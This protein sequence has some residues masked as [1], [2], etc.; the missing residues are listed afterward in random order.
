MVSGVVV[1]LHAEASDLDAFESVDGAEEEV[2]DDEAD[3]DEVEGE[4]AVKDYEQLVDRVVDARFLENES[5]LR[6][7]IVAQDLLNRTEDDANREEEGD[8]AKK[9]AKH[10]RERTHATA[11]LGTATARDVFQTLR[12]HLQHIEVATRSGLTKFIIGQEGTLRNVSILCPLVVVLLVCNGL[13]SFNQAN[14]QRREAKRRIGDPHDHTNS[15]QT[16]QTEQDG[17]LT[18]IRRIEQRVHPLLEIT[19]IAS[20]LTTSTHK[21]TNKDAYDEN[22]QETDGE[23]QPI[24]TLTA[25]ALVDVGSLIIEVDKRQHNEGKSNDDTVE[26]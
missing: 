11:A 24:Q 7:A 9:D 18:A 16:A 17:A 10:D 20:V 13:F 22:D 3:E 8:E 1:Q 12:A 2:D 14:R 6:A 21:Q 26:H 4:H 19:L 23:L 25:H 5:A 15:R